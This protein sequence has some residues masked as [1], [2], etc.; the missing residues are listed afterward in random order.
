MNYGLPVKNFLDLIFYHKIVVFQ[1]SL[2]VFC[3][4]ITFV[5]YE[6]VLVRTYI[7]YTFTPSILVLDIR[8]T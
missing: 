8:E 6:I 3:V 2:E 7:I 5:L 1:F 4:S